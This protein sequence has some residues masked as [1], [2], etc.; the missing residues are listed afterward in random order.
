MFFFCLQTGQRGHVEWDGWRHARQWALP[1][2]Q[3]AP[4]DAGVPAAGEPAQPRAGL[5]A[6]PVPH[7]QA[8]PAPVH[9]EVPRHC[10]D[11][12]V[13]HLSGDARLLYR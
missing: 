2:R 9:V 6:V 11:L 4:G 12:P 10:H 3:P 13:C 8:M 1:A 7:R 5:L